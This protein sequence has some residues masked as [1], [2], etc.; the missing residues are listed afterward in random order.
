MVSVEKL[1]LGVG[2]S[3]VQAAMLVSGLWGIYYFGEVKGTVT[4]SK[5]LLAALTTLGGIIL[6][7]KER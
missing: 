5:W 4:Q 3:V 2:Y 1:G 7:S 6:L